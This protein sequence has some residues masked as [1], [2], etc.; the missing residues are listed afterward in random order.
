MASDNDEK[1]GKPHLMRRWFG[2]AEPV[3]APIDP[4][5]AIEAEPLD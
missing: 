3:T 2:A 1:K 5:A 4:P